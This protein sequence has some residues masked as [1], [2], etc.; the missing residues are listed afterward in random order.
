MLQHDFT[1]QCY[2]P[3]KRGGKIKDLLAESAG[4][5]SMLQIDSEKQK[6]LCLK[7]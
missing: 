5:K 3:I 7:M 6:P 1:A 2:H 4:N